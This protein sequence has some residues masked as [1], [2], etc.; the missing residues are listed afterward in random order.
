VKTFSLILVVFLLVISSQ[1]CFLA[2]NKTAY[3]QV[4]FSDNFSD[5]SKN[6]DQVNSDSG[7]TDY[8]DGA[9]RI[10]VNVINSKAW[11]SPGNESFIDTRIEVNAT[12]NS[13]PDNND[14]GIIC[15]YLDADRFY[16]AVISSDGYYGIMKM[17][18]S[19][20]MLIG[21]ESMLESNAILKGSV[22]NHLR[23]DCIGSTITLYVNGNQVDQQS[24][25]DYT[26][27]NVGLLAGTFDTPGADILFDNFFV[28]K[29]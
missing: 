18:A 24:D 7:S 25:M 4:L 26:T 14:F 29:P 15:R 3:Q 5:P 1:A 8:F 13:G 11:A 16:Y 19:G 17:T 21:K 27:G 20:A 9:Y 12:K 23:L 6:W 10:L 28:Y 2:G 22:T